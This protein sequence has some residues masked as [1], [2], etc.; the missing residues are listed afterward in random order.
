MIVGRNEVI[1]VAVFALEPVVVVIRVPVVLVLV[2][3]EVRLT[4]ERADLE[5]RPAVMV[6]AQHRRAGREPGDEG[7]P[8]ESE[9]ESG[10]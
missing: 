10:G 4:V 9:D 2:L 5:R 1:V 6:R 3:V 7:Q 8:R